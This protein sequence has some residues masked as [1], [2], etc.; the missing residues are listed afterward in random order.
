MCR[1]VLLLEFICKKWG[2]CRDVEKVLYACY[3]YIRLSYPASVAS[4]SFL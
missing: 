1:V 4:L 3:G 2:K